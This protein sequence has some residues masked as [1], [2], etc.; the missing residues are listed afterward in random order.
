MWYPGIFKRAY[1]KNGYP[2]IKGSSM[3]DADPFKSC[4]QLSKTRT[5]GLDELWL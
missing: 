5:P 2:Y 3:F 1:V 4:D